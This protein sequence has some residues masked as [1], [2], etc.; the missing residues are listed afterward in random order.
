[1]D[2]CVCVCEL[3]VVIIDGGNDGGGGCVAAASHAFEF[4]LCWLMMAI[5]S[6]LSNH[7]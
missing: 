7:L 1:M 4:S 5:F 3:F 2:V 6:S